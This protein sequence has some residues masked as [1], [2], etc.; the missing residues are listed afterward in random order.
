MTTLSDAIAHDLHD[1]GTDVVFGIIS[2]HNLPIYDALE[3][4]GGFRIVTAR[5]EGG[6]VNMAD[7]YA[8][9]SGKLG[10]VL[11]STGTGAGNAAGGLI[12]A[13]T[14]GTPLLHITGQVVSDYLD[15]GRGYIHEF[16][17]QLAMLES[18]SKKAFR[19]RRAVDGVATV[20]RAITEAMKPPSG[21]VSVEIPI[22]FQAQ[23]VEPPSLVVVGS[24][25]PPLIPEQLEPVI[26]KLIH[27]KRP[28]I[29]SGGGVVRSNSS[30]PLT[31]LAELLGA[32]V[33]TSQSG[34]G[35]IPESHP[36]CVGHF[37]T[38]PEA[39]ELVGA[40]DLVLSIGVRFRGNETSNWRMSIPAVHI[41]VDADTAATNRNFPHSDI[42]TGDAALILPALVEGVRA[43]APASKPD[44][45]EEVEQI[46]HAV[47][48]R[49]RNTLGPWEAMLDAI[50]ETLPESAVV[51][52]DITT[53]NTTWGNRLI[54]TNRPRASVHASGGGIGQALPMAVG[55][56]IAAPERS[57][58]LL[59]G[60]GGFLFNVGDLA[61]VRD[62]NL[63]LVMV[64]Y[65]DS[66]YGVIRNIQDKYLEGRKVGVN[67]WTPDFVRLAEAFEIPA[68]R[69]AQ[70][71]AFRA[72][73]EKALGSDEAHLIVVDVEGIGAMN[74]PFCGPPG[75]G[76]LLGGHK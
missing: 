33:I 66:G 30:G 58:V 64:V 26:T 8:R 24:A 54:E 61:T 20:R 27:A 40:A 5:S 23:F 17:D 69:V 75:G 35:S 13:V 67:L 46:R 70:P 76:E 36:L 44:F 51:V 18:L 42:L 37:A 60:D 45:K 52:R 62:E 29:W 38:Y 63:P 32:A 34:R 15:T 74:E 48:H 1:L 50:S 28:V 3:R 9:V 25:S 41:G 43:L 16:Q 53:P 11:T 72:A 39:K 65:D 47:R 12:E 73:F 22:D 71:A 49:L 10:V 59:S 7:A 55:A 14:A 4:H 57:T 6:A 19:V 21:P 31:E 68:V 2:I 56:Q